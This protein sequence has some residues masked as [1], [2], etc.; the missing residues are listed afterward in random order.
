VLSEPARLTL[1]S[2]SEGTVLVAPGARLGLGFAVSRDVN[3][4][5]LF[6]LPD[7]EPSIDRRCAA[8]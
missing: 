3:P 1:A 6:Q 2:L 8:L 4:H 7:E 5:A